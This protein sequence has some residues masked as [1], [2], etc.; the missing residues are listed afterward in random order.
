VTHVL[1][2]ADFVGDE[3][4]V[5]LGELVSLA[6]EQAGGASRGSRRVRRW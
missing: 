3:Q 2:G 1:D 5:E 6:L 4:E